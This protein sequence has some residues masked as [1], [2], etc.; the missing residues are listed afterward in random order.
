ML[1]KVNKKFIYIFSFFFFI[2]TLNICTMPSHI[3]SGEYCCQPSEDCEIEDN[4]PSVWMR[5]CSSIYYCY[6]TK[7]LHYIDYDYNYID[8]TCDH[9]VAPCDGYTTGYWYQSP[10]NDIVCRR[11]HRFHRTSC[12]SEVGCGPI[13]RWKCISPYQQQ[14]CSSG[15]ESDDICP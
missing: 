1:G 13:N 8:G 15:I 12:Q 9:L 3:A 4:Y 2:I 5:C 11:V 6:W 7:E 14:T 10:P